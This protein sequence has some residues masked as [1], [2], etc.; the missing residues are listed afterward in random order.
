MLAA[1]ESALLALV[2]AYGTTFDSANSALDDWRVAL[3][4]QGP[5]GAVIEQAADTEE[6]DELD[7]YPGHGHRVQAHELLVSVAYKVGGGQGGDAEATRAAKALGEALADHIAAYERLDGGTYVRRA[8]VTRVTAPSEVRP[9]GQEGG[10]T[11]I[12]VGVRVRVVTSRAWTP[13]EYS[14]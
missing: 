7:G 14:S 5:V 11:H 12:V 8:R 1:A 13:A 6:A 9:R 4:C 10:P 3:D 2:R